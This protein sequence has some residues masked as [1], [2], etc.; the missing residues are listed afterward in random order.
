MAH[1]NGTKKYYISV[2]GG[3]GLNFGLASFISYIKTEGD[4]TGNKDYEF[5]VCSPYYDIF[6][7]CP[8]VSTVYKPNEIKDM[9]FDAEAADGELILHRLYDMDGFIKKQLNYSEAWA[10]LMNIP[11]TD[12]E[13]GTKAKSILEPLKK[14][15][16]L[17]NHVEA[18]KKALD[19]KDYVIMQ[20]TGGQS[21]L[22]QVPQVKNDKGEIVS[23]WSKVPYNYDNEPLKRHYPIDKAEAFVDAYHKAYPDRIIIMY[24]LP[25]EPCPNREFILRATVP[26]LTYYELAKEAKE[27]ICIDS[28]LQHLTAGLTKTTVIWAHSKPKS[29]GYSFNNNI[30]QPCRTDD[31][32]YFSAIGPSGAKVQYIEPEELMKEVTK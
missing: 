25:N 5:N 31:L 9:I 27:I 24:Q 10:K 30:E 26:Y 22:V 15:P 7:A 2:V 6:E 3:T 4:D 8:Y 18:I 28:S 17:S 1:K 23:D 21:P 16:G 12:T 20:F 29:F 32:L 19:G 11:F 14:F 13:N